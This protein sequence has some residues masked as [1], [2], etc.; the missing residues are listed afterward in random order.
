M[1]YSKVLSALTTFFSATPLNSTYISASSLTKCLATSSHYVNGLVLDV[2]CGEK[3]HEKIFTSK[4]DKYIGVDLP[5]DAYIYGENWQADVCGT[6][7]DLPFLSNSVDTIICTGV[8]PHIANPNKAFSEFARVLKAGGIIVITAGKSW[9][10]R[11]N[12]PIKDYWRFTDDGLSYLAEQQNLKVIYTEPS[13]GFLATHG[14]L[15]ARFL[16][17]QFLSPPSSGKHRH[18]SFF[19]LRSLFVSPLCA[20]VQLVSLALE[21]ICYSNLDTLFYIMVAQKDNV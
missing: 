6:A 2:G 16:S 9:L 4:I 5:P 3:P 10:K 17:K 14:Q 11:Q 12:L 13:C 8:L 1:I 20:A 19:L 7:T 21:K 15:L 18:T